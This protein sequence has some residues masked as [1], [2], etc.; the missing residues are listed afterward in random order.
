M[1]AHCSMNL[2]IHRTLEDVD[3]GVVHKSHKI[4]QLLEARLSVAKGNEQHLDARWAARGFY[5]LIDSSYS[6]KVML[7]HDF[8]WSCTETKPALAA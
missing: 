8:Q 2:M 1:Y 7:E 4:D 6:L 5:L 3:L